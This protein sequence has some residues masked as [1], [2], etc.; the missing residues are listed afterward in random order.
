M[1]LVYI[2]FAV[3]VIFLVAF[4]KK[5]SDVEGP[6]DLTGEVETSGDDFEDLNEKF[7]NNAEGRSP[8]PFVRTYAPKDKMLIRSILDSEGI[9]TYVGS[10][11][12]N[13]IL[14]GVRIQ[15][16]ADSVIYIF[17]DDRWRALPV[18]EDYIR[19][20]VESANPGLNARA[21]DFAAVLA[22]LPTSLN[23]IVPEILEEK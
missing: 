18:V 14:P 13:N 19:D 16:H 12:I 3:I 5:K 9:P 2:L 6:S 10:E 17:R 4:L 15:G 7:F 11:H 20:L 23:Q 1:N 21:I 8:I 22:A